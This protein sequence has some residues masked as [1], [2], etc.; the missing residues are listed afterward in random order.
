MGEKRISCI[1]FD[2]KR[3]RMITCSS[4]IC[5]WPL[6]RSV[7]DTMQI[8]HTHER[9]LVAITCSSSQIASVCNESTIKVWESDTGRLLYAIPQGKNK[10]IQQ[11]SLR[12]LY[13]VDR[14]S[15]SPRDGHRDHLY[16]SWRERIS[17]GNRSDE[18]SVTSPIKTR[19]TQFLNSFVIST[20]SI[21]L[22]D[23]GAGQ[24][25]KS[26]PGKKVE[27][28]SDS[29]IFIN[30][31]KKNDEAMILACG[32]SNEIRMFLDSNESNQLVYVRTL[33]DFSDMIRDVSLSSF[34]NSVIPPIKS[35]MLD[36]YFSETPLDHKRLYQSSTP[37]NL[38]KAKMSTG[39]LKGIATS[40][41]QMNE[42]KA[43]FNRND[44][45]LNLISRY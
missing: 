10:K 11:S 18:W 8:P 14:L 19:S 6:A 26:L 7:Q 23:F 16:E 42:S 3:D 30:Y 21:K 34:S 13:Q 41:A 9:S 1:E 20:G 43:K 45:R 22:W 31:F 28:Q 12:K 32:W 44:V 33:N 36:D 17:A 15:F 27:T 25:I 4:V 2:V 39:E 24:E 37:N 5:C 29:I 35:S 40:S 38:S